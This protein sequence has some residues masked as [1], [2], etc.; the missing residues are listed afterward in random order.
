METETT[1]SESRG[2]PYGRDAILALELRCSSRNQIP[3]A[4]DPMP[5]PGAL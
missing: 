3:L 5:Y 2:H 1:W 4:A